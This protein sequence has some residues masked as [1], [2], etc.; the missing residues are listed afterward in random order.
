M[1]FDYDKT[2][3][4]FKFQVQ[5]KHWELKLNGSIPESETEI[6]Q[7]DNAPSD[8][9]AMNRGDFEA[10]L[11]EIKQNLSKSAFGMFGFFS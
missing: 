8:V 6:R 11:E 9:L 1:S 5:S 7:L 3:S 4:D 10:L 2:K